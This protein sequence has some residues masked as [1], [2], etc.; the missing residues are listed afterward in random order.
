[1]TGIYTSSYFSRLVHFIFLEQNKIKPIHLHQ[2]CLRIFM[3]T[4]SWEPAEVPDQMNHSTANANSK[5]V[6]G[7]Q[8]LKKENYNDNLQVSNNK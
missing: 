1:M 3:L 4:C 5:V 8:I 2:N 7:R 6:V